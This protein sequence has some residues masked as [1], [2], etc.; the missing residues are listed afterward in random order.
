MTSV[1][2]AARE[3]RLSTSQPRWPACAWRL[4]DIIALRLQHF[5]V[6]ALALPFFAAATTRSGARHGRRIL[7]HQPSSLTA[8]AATEPPWFHLL[9]LM[10]PARLRLLV[11]LVFVTRRLLQPSIQCSVPQA[12]WARLEAS[13]VILLLAMQSVSLRPRPRWHR[14]DQLARTMH[15][16]CPSAGC[17]DGRTAGGMP[18]SD[19]DNGQGEQRSSNAG[20]RG[21]SADALICFSSDLSRAIKRR[22]AGRLY[23]C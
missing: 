12:G 11:L 17:R 13:P 22:G 9:L 21:A 23:P 19:P 7:L 4:A 14:P 10:C 1:N 5:H 16:P 2:G 8:V 3:R 20:R 18:H 6:Y 15:I